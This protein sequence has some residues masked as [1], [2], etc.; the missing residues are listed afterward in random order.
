MRAHGYISCR[1]HL[2]RL[3]ESRTPNYAVSVCIFVYF[4]KIKPKKKIFGPLRIVNPLQ[5][6][7]SYWRIRYWRIS[8]STRVNNIQAEFEFWLSSSQ[9]YSITGRYPNNVYEFGGNARRMHSIFLHQCP[10]LTSK[11]FL[12]MPRPHTPGYP[13]WEG[14]TRAE[15]VAMYGML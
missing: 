7:I 8:K 10:S 4:Y 5:Y 12:D 6:S 11:H 1:S 13:Y 9:D 15:L 2:L 3:R 14:S